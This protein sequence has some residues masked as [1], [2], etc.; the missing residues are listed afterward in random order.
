MANWRMQL[1]PSQSSRAI[2]DTVKCLAAGYIGLDFSEDVPDML[3]IDRERLPERQRNYFAFAHELDVN[4]WV[5]LFAHHYPF[6][7]ARVTGG[8]N[9]L[10]AAVPELRAWFGHFRSVSDIHFYGDWI[11]VPQW[12]RITMTGTIDPL[13]EPQSASYQLIERWRQYLVQG[14]A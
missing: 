12:E 4:D 6:A 8:Y 10:K 11:S 13:R 7:L 14:A 2:A 3:T 1:H 5:L 9:Y